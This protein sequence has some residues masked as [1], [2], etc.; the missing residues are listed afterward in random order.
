MCP[1]EIEEVLEE[2][3]TEIPVWGL[4]CLCVC[5]H[6][7]LY[8]CYTEK[9]DDMDFTDLSHIFF[10]VSEFFQQRKLMTASLNK[11]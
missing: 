11:K 7:H 6:A 9:K 10:R 3:A 8:V 4:G 2:D 5:P 1:D